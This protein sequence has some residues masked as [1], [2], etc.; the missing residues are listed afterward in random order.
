MKISYKFHDFDFKFK[1]LRIINYKTIFAFK[2]ILAAC[3]IKNLTPGLMLTA[4]LAPSL[5]FLPSRAKD[6]LSVSID[7]VTEDLNCN[8]LTTPSPPQ[9]LPL[10]PEFS[11]NDLQLLHHQQQF[12]SNPNHLGQMLYY[13]C[14][15]DYLQQ[16]QM[17]LTRHQQHVVKLIHYHQQRQHSLM[18]QWIHHPNNQLIPMFLIHKPKN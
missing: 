11:R 4:V 1:Y 2:P 3:V 9:Y 10:P 18:D 8:S 16:H 17:L 15:L 14:N 13:S 7:K 6:R 12:H 5:I